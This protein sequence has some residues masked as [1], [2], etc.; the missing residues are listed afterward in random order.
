M[1][2]QSTLKDI[3][4]VRCPG[5]IEKGYIVIQDFTIGVIENIELYLG[6]LIK[7]RKYFEDAY[8]YYNNA[9]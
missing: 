1:I 4:W 6:T 7:L 2:L 8:L 5:R 3:D 9:E